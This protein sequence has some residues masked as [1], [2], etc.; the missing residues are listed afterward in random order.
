M[1]TLTEPVECVNGN[2]YRRVVARPTFVPDDAQSRILTALAALAKQ[3]K[4]VEVRTDAL[5]AEAERAGIPI[6]HIAENAELT[7]K[8]VYRHL[9]KPMK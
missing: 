5:I 9:G 6:F 7:R 8:T 4:A 1:G 3:R 2:S